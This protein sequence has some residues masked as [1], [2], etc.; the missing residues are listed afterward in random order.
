MKLKN[1]A[2]IYIGEKI[3]KRNFETVSEAS[4]FYSEAKKIELFNNKNQK[5]A[6]L[7]I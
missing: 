5:L 4:Y 2:I 1:Y 6:T 3:I 7:I